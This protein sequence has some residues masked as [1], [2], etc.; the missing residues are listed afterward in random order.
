[1]HIR[2]SEMLC[3]IVPDF[4]SFY[5]VCHVVKLMILYPQQ[6]GMVP[7]PNI[8]KPKKSYSIYLFSLTWNTLKTCTIN[9]IKFILI[10]MTF[11]RLSRR[12]MSIFGS[13]SCAWFSS[14]AIFALEFSALSWCLPQEN[15]INPYF[16]AL[17]TLSSDLKMHPWSQV[18]FQF[19]LS[20]WDD[21]LFL[22]FWL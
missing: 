16:G 7:S 6:R 1:M 20:L 12:F 22:E 14:S 10:I 19:L 15:E 11:K 17:T 13:P 3:H 5:W 2:K 9:Q 18:N 8:K 4:V 21:F